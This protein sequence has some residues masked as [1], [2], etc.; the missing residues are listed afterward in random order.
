MKKRHFFT[1]FT[2]FLLISGLVV[3]AFALTPS[4]T[5]HA[6]AIVLADANTGDIIYAQNEHEQ[7]NPAST[8]KIMTA[9]LA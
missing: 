9:L 1:L 8:T 2:L 3:S 6:Y 5:H 7:I 4:P